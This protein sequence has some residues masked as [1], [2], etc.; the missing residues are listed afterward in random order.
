MMRLVRRMS[1]VVALLLASIGSA[2]AECAWVL[3]TRVNALEWES[4]GGFNTREDCERERGKS[5]EGPLQA[6]GGKT[7]GREAQSPLPRVGTGLRPVPRAYPSLPRELI[8]LL[9]GERRLRHVLKE[10]VVHYHEERNHQGLDNDL[11]ASAPR[12]IGSARVRRHERVG[13]LLRYYYKAA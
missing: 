2:S 10:F 3:W 9:F 5:A 8:S 7:D 6:T 1:L 11:I 13:G 12:A 4:R